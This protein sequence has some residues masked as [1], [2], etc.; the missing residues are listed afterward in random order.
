MQEGTGGVMIEVLSCSRE[1]AA[2]QNIYNTLCQ[3]ITCELQHKA[4]F[5]TGKLQDREEQYFNLS[6]FV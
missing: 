5:I 4:V 1:Y 6:S 2:M 3:D